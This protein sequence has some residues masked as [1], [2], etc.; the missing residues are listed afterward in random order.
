VKTVLAAVVLAV[1]GLATPVA[2]QPLIGVSLDYP[3]Y[4]RPGS[5][6]PVLIYI[7]NES[8]VPALQIRFRLQLPPGSTVTSVTPPSGWAC[9]QNGETL[10]C[11]AASLDRTIGSHQ[12]LFDLKLSD[13]R[14][15]GKYRLPLTITSSN[16]ETAEDALQIDVPR[17][18]TVRSS[19]DDGSGSL[20]EALIE[21][22][23][24]C[25]PDTVCEI[26]FD[27]PSGTTFE[28]LTPLPVITACGSLVIDG[29]TNIR[30]GDRPYELSGARVV[31][32]GRSNGFEYRPVC[33]EPAH[34]KITGLAINRFADDGI[35]LLPFS[36]RVRDYRYSDIRLE[37]LFVGTDRTGRE[38]RPNGW[39]GIT[40][41]SNSAH[42][43]IAG[44]ILSGNGR[45]GA[46]LFRVAFAGIFGCL[47]GTSADGQ[48]LGNGAAGIFFNEG[49]LDADNNVIAYN[50]T[51]GVALAHRTCGPVRCSAQGVADVSGNSI[52]SN[53]F[54]G[55]DWGLDGRNAPRGEAD[56]IPNAPTITSAHYDAATNTTIIQGSLHVIENLMGERYDIHIYGNRTPNAYGRWEG[57][58]PNLAGLSMYPSQP[59]YYTW[60]IPR[61]G[62]LRGMT[63][64]ATTGVATYAD[65][66]PRV[67]SEFS[68]A[69]PVQ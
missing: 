1:L 19:I 49:A 48:P 29:G 37:G 59:G 2:A 46:Y 40:S 22:N 51:F 54:M 28:P 14:F 5:T 3:H 38:A 9:A 23:S 31:T 52:H 43:R 33:V 50:T 64:T 41:H 45:S 68:E 34:L 25:G 66:P 57:E 56:G 55:I 27:L 60:T 11:D 12:L 67:S 65:Y 17:L 44:S 21:A 30:D 4:A 39:R 53:E 6:L 32:D 16:A 63:L 47:I 69:V 15:G 13:D 35:A 20:R 7:Y 36:T 61:G 26:N 8:N 58:T 42:V 62:D 10:A 24:E 18:I